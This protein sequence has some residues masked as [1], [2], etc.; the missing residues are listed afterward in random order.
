MNCDVYIDDVKVGELAAQNAGAMHK[1]KLFEKKDLANT[2]H[3]LRV[4]P[5]EGE[6]I[7]GKVIQLDKIVVFHDEITVP[8]SIVLNRTELTMTPGASSEL[9]A[10]VIPWNANA[11]LVWTSSDSSV[12]EVNDGKLTAKEID[13]KKTVTV[14]AASAEDNSVLAE[15]KITVDPALAFMNAYVGNEKLLETELDYDKLKAGN[16]SV[17]NGTAWLN[18]EL[19]SKI[20]WTTEKDVHNVQVTAS[21]FKNEKGQV[22]SKDNIDIKWLKEIAAKE[23]RNAQGRQK[24]IRM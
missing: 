13:V 12:V 22:L 19:N 5:K 24:I 11:K 15:A 21:D 3:T 23:G 6:S 7:E 9:T 1:Q 18:D 4:V 2:K 8:D 20:V 17:Y 10:S 16:G 14:T